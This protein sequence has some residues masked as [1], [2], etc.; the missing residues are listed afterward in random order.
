M[1]DSEIAFL[2]IRELGAL[3]RK[4]DLSPV[5]L[6]NLYLSRLDGVGRSLRAVATV[7]DDIA[8]REAR[9]AEA[10]IRRRFRS[11]IRCMAFLTA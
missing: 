5:D 11:R 1:N 7:T 4:G 3:L 2:S 10:E 9:L 8:L 6:T